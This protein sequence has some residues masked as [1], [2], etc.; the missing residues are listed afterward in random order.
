MHFSDAL[1]PI[2]GSISHRRLTLGHNACLMRA[3]W[4]VHCNNRQLQTMLFKQP[5]RS[6]IDALDLFNLLAGNIGYM[7]LALRAVL[8]N[9]DVEIR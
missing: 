1:E 6:L 7:L 2:Q 9:R 8:V 4:M 3:G 5:T